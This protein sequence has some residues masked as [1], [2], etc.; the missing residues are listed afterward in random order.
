[1]REINEYL[2]RYVQTQNKHAWINGFPPFDMDIID[3]ESCSNFRLHSKFHGQYDVVWIYE[4]GLDTYHKNSWK[5]VVDECIRLLK[6]QG[7]LICKYKQTAN[8]TVPMLKSFIG[9]NPNLE[10]DVEYEDD[11]SLVFR[12]KRLNF[13][14]Y[15]NKLWTFSIL[16]SGKK[17]DN[18]IRFLQSIR[19]QDKEA[20]HEIIIS[21]P[22]KASYDKYNVKYLDQSQ[23]R[24]EQF[25]EI[26]KKKNA[27]AQMASNPNLLIA[28]DRFYLDK[29]FLSSFD[30]YGYDFDFLSVKQIFENK[31]LHPYYTFVYEPILSWTHPATTLNFRYLFDTQ[32][33]NGGLM[34]FKTHNLKKVPFNN[35]LFWNEQEDVEISKCFM[36][37]SLIPRVVYMP[38]TY[39]QFLGDNIDNQYD[40]VLYTNPWILEENLAI[41][42]KK[43]ILLCH[44]IVANKLSFL[45]ERVFH[46]AFLHNDGYK[47]A[48]KHNMHFLSNS[49]K[50]DKEICDFYHPLHHSFLPPLMPASFFDAMYE[51]DAKKEN[52]IILA[53]PFDKRKG[54]D[55]IP[56]Y[57]NAL[58]NELDTVYVFGQPRCSENDWRQFWQ[59]TTNLNIK[60]FSSIKNEDLINLY[61]KSKFLLFPS[62][63]EGLG[64]PLIEAQICG[65][66]VVTTDF[67]PMNKLAIDGILLSDNFSQYIVYI[68][69]AL[70]QNYNYKNLADEARKN[71][72]LINVYNHMNKI[73][74][75]E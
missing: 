47:Y 14:K 52:A 67:P 69:N 54:L 44:D 25:A 49:E 70:R 31:M 73:L 42:A 65:C 74:G 71:F 2:L 72:S 51:K 75:D 15:Q 45:D 48:K 30:E 37:H 59:K 60:Y 12:I 5:I 41:Q 18:V 6:E 58:K 4:K 28:H 1:M 32:Y 13:G 10:V 17:D 8:F 3:I 38:N 50:T 43:H 55:I 19:N 26:S 46:W 7:V 61:K 11:S 64:I 40:V 62:L 21:G 9:R 33:V 16:T 39:C 24:D 20:K 66:R 68:K 35:L 57:L 27:I 29:D 53:A 63:E 36:E 23:F 56:E 34:V 22:H